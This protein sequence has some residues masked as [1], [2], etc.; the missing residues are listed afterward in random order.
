MPTPPNLVGTYGKGRGSRE[1][2]RTW[3]M[4]GDSRYLLPC[5]SSAAFAVL[6][7]ALRLCTPGGGGIPPPTLPFRLLAALGT[8]AAAAWHLQHEKSAIKLLFTDDRGGGGASG[9]RRTGPRKPARSWCLPAPG[10]CR[11]VPALR[12]THTIAARK[13]SSA[14]LQANHRHKRSWVPSFSRLFLFA[15]SLRSPPAPLARRLCTH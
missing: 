6:Q 2:E 3:S 5:P 14:G 8:A 13:T 4:V 1:A 7:L 10:G 9:G 15:R 12:R 11:R